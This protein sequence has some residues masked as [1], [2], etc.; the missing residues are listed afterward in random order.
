[1]SL[2]NRF[3]LAGG[4]VALA[5]LVSIGLLASPVAAATLRTSATTSVNVPLVTN[6]ATGTSAGTAIGNVTLTCG[7][8]SDIAVS[9]TSI[10][11][12]LSN[13]TFQFDGT[14]SP[15]ATKTGTVVV[16]TPGTYNTGLTTVTFAV[17]TACAAGDTVTISGVRVKPVNATA[18]DTNVVFTTAGG[19][20]TLA[21]VPTNS[22]YKQTT[23]E[24][25]SVTVAAG[26]AMIVEQ[27]GGN[28]GHPSDTFTATAGTFASSG[29]ATLFCVDNASCDTN[30]LV[31]AIAVS[32]IAPATG[33]ATVTSAPTGGTGGSLAVNSPSGTPTP[34]PTATATATP[35]PGTGT[36]ISGSIPA[37]GGFGLIVY[38]GGTLQQLVTATGCP[39]ASMALWAT[40]N[41]SFITYV[42]GTTITAVNAEFMTTYP[43][44]IPANTPFVGK[45]Q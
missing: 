17:T 34:T 13:A 26:S 38:G 36:I 31:G 35:G 21:L 8:A 16:T 7:A 29:S 11:L 37:G 5:A 9:A 2:M 4:A 10:V 41:G 12:S 33:G 19:A 30:A 25:A 40:A 1:M 27:A 6:M 28:A 45:C 22:F 44:N 15:T 39:V 24:T 42:P 3:V 18:D 20:P 23:G 14:P 32:Y 43:G